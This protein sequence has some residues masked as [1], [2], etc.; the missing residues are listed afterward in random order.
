[1]TEEH[2]LI[3]NS[4]FSVENSDL[5]A[6]HRKI[7]SALNRLHCLEK[8]EN[9]DITVIRSILQDLLEYTERHCAHE[10]ELMLRWRFEGYD[11]QRKAHQQMISRTRNL[12]LKPMTEGKKELFDQSV[13]LL[14]QWWVNHI[15]TMDQEYIFAMEAFHRGQT[16]KA[17]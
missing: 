5:D 10:E 13:V 14:N 16:G 17:G 6:E 2:F 8:E 3:W 1:M 4:A 7:M 12:V 15:R 9:I 11:R